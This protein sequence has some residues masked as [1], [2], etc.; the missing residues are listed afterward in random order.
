M[1]H[2]GLGLVGSTRRSDS[3]WFF[4]RSALV[5]DILRGVGSEIFAGSRAAAAKSLAGVAIRR[6]QIASVWHLGRIATDPLRGGENIVDMVGFETGGEGGVCLCALSR[7][8]HRLGHRAR[9]AD[10]QQEERRAQV[11]PHFGEAPGVI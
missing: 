10:H 1:D 7:W 5:R 8:R 9:S 2:L 3:L 11:L 6:P 4:T